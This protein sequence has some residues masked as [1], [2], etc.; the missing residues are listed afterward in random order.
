[1]NAKSITF[2][3]SLVNLALLLVSVNLAHADILIFQSSDNHS[4]YPSIPNYLASTSA[5]AAQFQTQN[6]QAPVLHLV[7]GDLAGVSAWTDIDHGML[8]YRLFTELSR[9]YNVVLNLGNHEAFDYLGETGNSLFK[10]QIQEYIRRT[11]KT[12]VTAN[13]EPGIDGL[14]LFKSYHDFSSPTGAK[15]RVVGLVLSDYFRYSSYSLSAHT[16]IL[17]RIN[18]ILEEAKRQLEKAATEQTDVVI[19]Q[20]HEAFELVTEMVHDLLEWKKTQ[21]QLAKV[22]VPV[23][24]AAHDHQVQQGK[25]DDTFIFDS[26]STFEFTQ[27]VLDDNG[28]VKQAKHFDLKAQ[29]AFAGYSQLSEGETKAL[30]MTQAVIRKISKLNNKVLETGIVGFSE[31]RTDLKTARHPLGMKLSDMMVDWAR[32]TLAAEKSIAVKDVISFYNSGTYRKVTPI[33]A[34]DLTLG[35]LKEM[36]PL[37]GEPQLFIMPGAR[38][39]QMFKTLR[40]YGVVQK[41]FTPQLPSHIK[42][43]KNF[44][45]LISDKGNW[46]SLDPTSEYAIALEP[47]LGTNGFKIADPAWDLLTAKRVEPQIREQLQIFIKYLPRHLKQAIDP[48]ICADLL[49]APTP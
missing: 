30:K 35:M 27:V 31:T 46:V 13:V 25:I 29:K 36:Y 41:Q 24:F 10:K 14:S 8:S 19:F 48:K 38:I 44:E 6:P 37:Q 32:D 5:L 22:G 47:W 11:Q 42:E 2:S 3:L 15:I 26:G 20:C 34:G 49:G 1:M 40:E 4:E 9:Q 21:P 23:V 43:G 45:L 39:Q 12:L 7:N 28:H 17:K 16:Q 18:P 33:S